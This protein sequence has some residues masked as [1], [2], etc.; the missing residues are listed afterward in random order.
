M[1]DRQYLPLAEPFPAAD[2]PLPQQTL[3]LPL[4]PRRARLEGVSTFYGQ[5]DPV[6]TP[7]FTALLLTMPLPRARLTLDAS[8]GSLPI[9]A[10]TPFP[11]DLATTVV[12]GTLPWTMLPS[13]MTPGD[14]SDG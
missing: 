4:P 9:L 13:G 6:V 5:A 12:A 11:G 7:D 1:A 10:A 3:P 2:T 14:D 8:G